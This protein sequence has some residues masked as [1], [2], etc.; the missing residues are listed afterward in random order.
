MTE[1]QKAQVIINGKILTMSG[2][3]DEEYLQKIANYI[4]RKIREINEQISGKSMPADLKSICIEINIAD[5]LMKTRER[6]SQLEQDLYRREEE[7]NLARQEL[8]ELE[9]RCDQIQKEKDALEAD[10]E[11]GQKE[12]STEKDTGHKEHYSGKNK[13]K[14]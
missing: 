2:Y 10:R 8:A 6:A 5:E 13:K 3:E 7:L 11:N 14:R 1:K 4:N 12:A 9:V